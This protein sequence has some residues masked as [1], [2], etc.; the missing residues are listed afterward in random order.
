[1]KTTIHL[2]EECGKEQRDFVI[3]TNSDVSVIN[4]L[5]EE[6]IVPLLHAMGF[7]ENTINEYLGE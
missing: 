1:M 7:S 5:I 3:S 4:D 2:K 6:L